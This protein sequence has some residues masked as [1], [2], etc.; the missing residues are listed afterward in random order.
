MAGLTSEGFVIKREPEIITDSELKAKEVIDPNVYVRDDEFLG[1]QIAIS[2]TQQAEMWEVLE[3]LYDSWNID[4]AEGVTLD[5][6]GILRYIYRTEAS[7]AVY[8]DQL[9]TGDDG[10]TIAASTLMVATDGTEFYVKDEVTIST[11]SCSSFTINIEDVL[12][13]EDYIVTVDNVDYTIT[14]DSDATSLEIATQIEG[15]LDTAGFDTTLVGETVQVVLNDFS[16]VQLISYLSASEVTSQGTV[17][18]V[19]SGNI[20]LGANTLNRV[21]PFVQGLTSTTNPTSIAGGTDRQDDESYR[22]TIKT[23]RASANG[24]TEPAIRGRLLGIEGVSSVTIEE[25]DEPIT[26]GT[27]PPTSFECTVVGGLD[28][29]IADT[30]WDTRSQ[31]IRTHGNTPVSVT[32]ASGQLKVVRFSRPVDVNLALRI[33]YSTYTEEVVTEELET[34]MAEVAEEH[35]EVLS[36]G[37]DFYPERMFGDIYSNTSGVGTLLVEYQII[38]DSGDTP[39]G[40]W[41]STP[42]SVAAAEKVLTATADI[43]F[44]E[45]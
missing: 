25:N 19:V 35:V 10:A 31:G 4:K 20:T 6:L 2:A 22:Q 42:L 21:I 8:E 13:D 37:V 36:S 34:V 17:Q 44:V 32:A 41:V 18:A 7:Q 39:S 26:V 40:T 33:T 16:E 14:S 38:T 27:L 43:S 24:G 9:F 28:Q 3:N 11:L 29:D 1:Q 45:V 30:I 12:N 5:N 15:V 23:T